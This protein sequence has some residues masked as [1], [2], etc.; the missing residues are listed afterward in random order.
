MATTVPDRTWRDPAL[1][2]AA[3]AFG[4]VTY[5]T[6]A[7]WDRHGGVVALLDLV[8]GVVATA[9]LW[10]RKRW[11]VPIALATLP[12]G[13]LATSTSG[14]GLV[15]LFTVAVHRPLRSVMPVAALYV[16]T[17]GV[18]F[19]FYPDKEIAWGW[20]MVMVAVFVAAHVGWGMYVRA[21]RALVDSLRE[22]AERAEAEQQLRAQQA[23]DGERARIAREMH[24]VLAHRISLL[25]MHAGALEFRPDA[26]PHEIAQAA[27]VIRRSAHEALEDL[28]EVIGVLRSDAGES[29][30]VDAASGAPARPQPTLG[31]LDA[32]LAESRAAGMRV[33]AEVAV[34]AVPAG[35][36][37]TAYR[38]VQEGLTNAR[39]HADGAPVDVRLHGAPGDGLTVEVDNPAP[40]GAAVGASARIPGA[41]S[42]LLGLRER[43]QLAGGRLEHGPTQDGGF[44]LRVWLPWPV[45]AT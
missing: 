27:G 40:V 39:K 44:R 45:E 24:D 18:Y 15:V 2:A 7:P 25:S 30:E 26:P 9:A 23:R 13:M 22:R 38:V 37:R 43:A 36:G 32:L 17:A 31:D 10:W 6:D 21:R 14:A 12:L 16:A 29:A 34:G 11:P 4:L 1:I 33:H 3:I 28:R 8:A 42:G 5:M 20:L 19:R 35:L 41:G